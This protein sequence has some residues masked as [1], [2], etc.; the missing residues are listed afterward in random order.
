MKRSAARRTDGA[1][2]RIFP[3]RAVQLVWLLPAGMDETG[4]LPAWQ[5]LYERGSIF[6][7]RHTNEATCRGRHNAGNSETAVIEALDLE[8]GRSPLARQLNEAARSPMLRVSKRKQGRKT[9]G[10]TTEL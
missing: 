10:Q 6:R 8:T 5:R 4:G 7:L 2:R 3:P 9:E 1:R